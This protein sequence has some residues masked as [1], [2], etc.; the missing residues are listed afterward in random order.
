MCT[1]MC[2]VYKHIHTHTIFSTLYLY[3]REISHTYQDRPVPPLFDAF[4]YIITA[5]KDM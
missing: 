4:R 1:Y 2:V 3:I 5:Y